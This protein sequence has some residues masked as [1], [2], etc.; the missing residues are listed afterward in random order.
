MTY[1]TLIYSTVSSDFVSQKWRPKS[2]CPDVQAEVDLIFAA[3]ISSE[4]FVVA[5]IMFFIYII[6]I[7]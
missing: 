1:D 6:G 4:Y 3:H 5:W 2:D 7:H